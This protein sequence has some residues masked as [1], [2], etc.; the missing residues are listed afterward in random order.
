MCAASSTWRSK[1]RRLEDPLRAHERDT[2]AFET[3]PTSKDVARHDI[4]V[5]QALLAQVRKR[6][7]ANACVD[8]F[9]RNRQTFQIL[10]RRRPAI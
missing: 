6:C 1:D 8:V 7:R 4:A 5:E 2:R 10:D 3:E 9:S